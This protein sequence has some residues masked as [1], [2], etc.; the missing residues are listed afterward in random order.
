MVLIDLRRKPDCLV[1]GAGCAFAILLAVF[2]A[3]LN[4]RGLIASEMDAATVENGVRIERVAASIRREIRAGTESSERHVAE[5]RRFIFELD[6][7]GD[8]AAGGAGG[9]RY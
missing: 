2:G 3:V 9:S 5:I 8:D 4:L 7:E 6:S 1:V